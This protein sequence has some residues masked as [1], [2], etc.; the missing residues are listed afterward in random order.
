M[1]NEAFIAVQ[2]NRAPLLAYMA[3]G[4]GVYATRL[5]GDYVAFDTFEAEPRALWFQA[6]R[7]LSE[8]ATAA[9]YAA[10]QSIVFA[11]IG[12]EM[13]RPLWKISGD[14][15]SLRRFF[16]LWFLLDLSSVLLYRLADEFAKAIGN[17]SSAVTLL[18]LWIM[19]VVLFVPFGA[20]VMFYG[21]VRKE[22]IGQAVNTL[23]DQFPRFLAILLMGYIITSLVL[24][25][26]TARILPV[27]ALPSLALLDSFG[28]CLVF[29][30]TW[31]LC[32]DHRDE[33]TEG[34]D[35]DF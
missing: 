21:H 19:T 30:A 5:L 10:A 18:L 15:D 24:G 33:D 23:A 35:L 14:M 9:V 26:Q 13:D 12:A 6:Y 31:L 28:E 16:K 7:F 29:S 3:V 2:R 27:W 4:V 8:L 32:I 1:I 25:I 17:D 22:E 11:R 20:C 34:P